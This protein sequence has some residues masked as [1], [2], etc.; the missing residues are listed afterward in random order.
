MHLNEVLDDERIEHGHLP[1]LFVQVIGYSQVVSAGSFHHKPALRAAGLDQLL[2]S[3]F[4]TVYFQ[5][6]DQVIYLG[7]THVLSALMVFSPI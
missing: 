5:L 2:K 6:L 4:I 1:T 7:R 3:R